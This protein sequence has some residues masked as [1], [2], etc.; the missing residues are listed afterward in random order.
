M[1]GK[2]RLGGKFSGSHSTVIDHA[3]RVVDKAARL[4]EVSKIV[5]GMIDHAK[6]RRPRITFKEIP[7]GLDVIVHGPISKQTIY[8]YTSN[9]KTT[10]QALWKAS[11]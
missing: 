11:H 6:S 7:A 1:S 9:A 5:L 10:Q 4:E 2:H 8:V 3:V